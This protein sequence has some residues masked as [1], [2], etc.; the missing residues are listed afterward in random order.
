MAISGP[1]YAWFTVPPSLSPAGGTF[2]TPPSVSMTTSTPLTSIRY[3][4]DGT[5]PTESSPLYSSPILLT[6][7]TTLKAATFRLGWQTS[8]T[9][10]ATFTL[11]SPTVTP[12]VVSPNGGTF[13][14][15]VTV[16]LTSENGS[17]IRYTLDGSTPSGSSPLYT[18]PITIDQS[19][20]LQART[21]RP[22]NSSSQVTAAAFTIAVAAP[23]LS[24]AG[25]TYDSAQIV[26]M[27]SA[28]PGTTIRYTLDGTAPT[29]ASTVYTGPIP[30]EATTTIT[31]R[32]FKDGLADSVV[33][34]G[35]Y[36]FNYGTLDAPVITP[37]GGAYDGPQSVV[38]TGVPGATVRYTTDGSTPTAS[39]TIYSQPI[40]VAWLPSGQSQ[41]ITARAFK[42]DWATSSSAS[43]DYTITDV[44]PPQIAASV[45]PPPNPLGWNNSPVTVTFS[46]SDDA[47]GVVACPQPI[48]FTTEGRAQA[49]QGTAEDRA[50]HSA[51]TSAAVNI[52]L[53]P[54]RV[55][56][57]SPRHGAQ[58][59]EALVH[60]RGSTSDALSSVTSVSCNGT[61]VPVVDSAFQCDVTLAP[62]VNELTVSAADGAG[63][64][65]TRT[66]VV[67][68]NGPPMP[69]PSMLRIT[70][71]SFTLVIGG[72]QRLR[73]LDDLG[74][75]ADT[76]VWTVSD[77]EV[78]EVMSEGGPRLRALAAGQV[79][80]SASWQGL[81][82]TAQVTVLQGPSV[83][84]GTT[85][86]STP[87]SSP[88]GA[89]RIIK[90]TPIDHDSPAFFAVE[91]L[92]VRAFS[93]DGAELWSAG[94]DTPFQQ[95]SGD[96]QGGLL[97][98]EPDEDTTVGAT[99]RRHDASGSVVWQQHINGWPG[100]FAVHPNGNVYVV[101]ASDTV[102]EL[103]AISEV[104]GHVEGRFALPASSSTVDGQTTLVPPL[105]GPP[106]VMSDGSVVV[107]IVAADATGSAS[108][109]TVYEE[110]RQLYR[111]AADGT[112]SLTTIGS[113][114]SWDLPRYSPSEVFAGPDG[115]A[116]AT[117]RYWSV[118]SSYVAVTGVKPDG[119]VGPGGEV[120]GTWVTPYLGG[121]AVVDD[122][123]TFYGHVGTGSQTAGLLK[124]S[125]NSLDF[126]PVDPADVTE[127][128]VARPETG[129]VLGGPSG[130]QGWPT[131]AGLRHAMPRPDGSWIGTDASGGVAAVAGSTTLGPA[132]GWNYPGGNAQNQRAAN[133]KPLIVGVLYNSI[134]WDTIPLSAAEREV[135]VN[136]A[137]QTLKDAYAGFWVTFTAS[138]L[139]PHLIKVK[140]A[141]GDGAAGR[142]EWIRDPSYGVVRATT[143]D[144]YFWTIYHM[145]LD[146]VGCGTVDLLG[147]TTYSRG[148]LLQ[149]LGR[150]IGGTMAHELGHQRGCAWT[151][152]V[153]GCAACY[154]AKVM[155]RQSYFGQSKWSE[156]A[157]TVM[158]EKLL[159]APPPRR[160]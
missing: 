142:T 69:P 119:S 106:A 86:W 51:R 27:T 50:G 117:W 38:L 20:T 105:A 95:V 113:S 153:V 30:V 90:A 147:C 33:T 89:Y 143:S 127:I 148:D 17:S 115:V 85:L 11:N 104:S 103:L 36:T 58:L 72:E 150:G 44:A 28:T 83:P 130:P 56:V 81:T 149:A 88:G 151:N 108:P 152:D 43:A 84:D 80:V 126:V 49:A 92:V 121:H 98:L 57:A 4:T 53:T 157:R 141:L 47:S 3:T 55:D 138:P 74:R 10:T 97:A 122:S 140:N 124:V 12:P 41:T 75:R 101:D 70:P 91:A 35:T 159:P 63:N 25:G 2:T 132:L 123:G 102:G 116:F 37:P 144:V 107:A 136:T 9:T 21:Y 66:V 34:A 76:A 79:Q 61:A 71:P 48:V 19:L 5:I 14:G 24:P 133:W 65:G 60:L 67:S 135:V 128:L 15:Q 40:A 31:A 7:T 52:D 112:T 111:L 87:P 26:A 18:T 16:S 1:D 23:S 131:L 46:C 78:A 13:T 8:G 68:L 139:E 155:S 160:D 62:G 77:P 39:S 137:L 100:G 96:S 32:A 99:L 64:V 120:A 125:E 42:T 82:A 156:G 154:D 110:R 93:S 45:A 146:V 145:L 94:A 129:L 158:V 29:A 6:T 114:S 59:T 73:A 22:D 109:P 118:G 54:P 134:P